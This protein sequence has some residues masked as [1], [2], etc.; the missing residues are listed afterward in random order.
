M[1]KENLARLRKQSQLSQEFMARHLGLTRATYS[2]IEN[3]QKSPTLNE[4]EKLAEVLGIEIEELISRRPPAA[5]ALADGVVLPKAKP[6]SVGPRPKIKL[7]AAKLESVL[8]Y[9]LGKIG[10]QP[11]MGETVLYKLLYFIDFDYY[12]KFG[13]SITG[14]QYKH[15]HYGP[16]PGQTFRAL[17][18]AMTEKG[19]LKI[20]E[21]NFYDRPQK[22]YIAG[23]G[24]DLRA[25]SGQEVCHIDEALGRLG[26]KTAK[27]LTDLAHQD[28]PWLATEPGQ[29]IDYQLAKYRT[30]PTAVTSD[31][32]EL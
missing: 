1:F 8:L 23:T 30:T 9:V 27:E 18:K 11:N 10:S 31:E 2:K 12:E 20:V 5:E 24:A 4:V 13:Q 26:G 25:L 28:M 7:D 32:D 21:T 16:T 14:M 19:E 3:G 6:D 29:V 17:T 22:R 15:N